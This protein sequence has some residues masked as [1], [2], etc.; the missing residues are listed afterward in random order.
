MIATETIRE[1]AD[2]LHPL[3]MTDAEETEYDATAEWD[4]NHRW[5]IC[6]VVKASGSIL[7]GATPH[8]GS[9]RSPV[10]MRRVASVDEAV[11]ALRAMQ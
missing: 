5:L 9:E 2:R 4:S 1:I 10:P 3:V 8:I 7:V 6:E 11:E